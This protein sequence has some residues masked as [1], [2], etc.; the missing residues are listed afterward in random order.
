MSEES[1]E[2][3][4]PRKREIVEKPLTRRAIK[5]SYRRKL[6]E[7]R[8]NAEIDSLTGLPTRGAFDRRLREEASRLRR[9]GGKTTV[10]VLDADKLKQINDT[11]GH[12]EGDLYLKSI[13][14]AILAGIRR[15]EDFAARTGGDEFI[16]LLPDTNLEGAETMWENAL[17]PA[18]IKSGIAISGGAAEI[19]P[20]NPLESI[21]R[22]DSAMY[23]AK[24]DKD[25][26]GENL[27]YSFIDSKK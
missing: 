17:N 22:A 10:V 18:F 2:K 26:N 12:A 14:Q 27:L 5:K 24:H 8:D 6:Q 1:Y 13:A 9:G 7:V 21:S 25:R 4:E 3:T 15:E 16:L 19:D 11:K 23:G 20:I